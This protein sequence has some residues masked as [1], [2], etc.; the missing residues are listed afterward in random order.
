[1]A[2]KRT[3]AAGVPNHRG[4]STDSIQHGS[5][6]LPW[7]QRRDT[8]LG[9]YRSNEPCSFGNPCPPVRLHCVTAA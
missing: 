1:M 9:T 7:R 6:R 4:Q 8:F 2:G 3:G 5:L